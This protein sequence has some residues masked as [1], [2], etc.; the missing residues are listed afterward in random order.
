MDKMPQKFTSYHYTA[1]MT[2]KTESAMSKASRLLNAVDKDGT[3][4]T[5]HGIATKNRRGP[6]SHTYNG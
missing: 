1:H 4:F 2:E 5:F 6:E 3:L